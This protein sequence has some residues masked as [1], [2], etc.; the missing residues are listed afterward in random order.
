MSIS[1]VQDNS[2]GT[3]VV[4]TLVDSESTVSDARV[5]GLSA[6]ERLL[7][8]FEGLGLSMTEPSEL[9]QESAGRVVAIGTEYFYD[10]RLITALADQSEDLILSLNSSGGNPVPIAIVGSPTTVSRLLPVLRGE[11]GIADACE[12]TGVIHVAPTDLV[13]AFDSK[14]RK[15]APPY[16]ISASERHAD[17]ARARIFAA[18]YKGTTDFV[19]KWVWPRPAR[20]VTSWCADRGIMPNTVTGIGYILTFISLFAFW[21]GAFAIG[22]L[23]AWLMTFLD[24][25][26]G[27]L[28]RVTLTST[29]LGDVLDHGL[30]LIHPPFWWVAWMAGLAGPGVLFG[31]YLHWAWVVFAAYIVGRLLE[32]LFML[33]FGQEMFTWRP[34]DASFR[35]VIARR[36][37]NLVVL[38]VATLLGRPD[39]GIMIVVVWTVSCCLI[40]CVRI[41]QAKV[42]QRSGH[43]IESFQQ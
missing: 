19:T 15:Y 18:S 5:F 37:P 6:R 11:A 23:S 12:S 41:G 34:F 35:L 10:E 25:V 40:Q 16:V 28:A 7:R 26:D 14:L 39:L 17:E 9:A 31:D 33:L 21:E 38:T 8:T 29:R 30:D 43:S 4:A 36:N 13:P 20:A 32:G 27:K 24:T 22:L 42:A 2:S 3:R 1:T